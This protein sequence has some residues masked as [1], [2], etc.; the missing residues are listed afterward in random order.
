MFDFLSENRQKHNFFRRL[1]GCNHL[2]SSSFPVSLHV[3]VRA[4]MLA[5]LAMLAGEVPAARGSAPPVAVASDRG[6]PLTACAH[7]GVL[8]LA[9]AGKRP[10]APNRE[11]S[12]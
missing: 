10:L 7:S 2:P 9:V 1:S 5:M 8:D 12:P 3:L 6:H 11:T 4:R